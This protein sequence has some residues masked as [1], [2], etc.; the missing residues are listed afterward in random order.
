MT[1]L[2]V[3]FFINTGLLIT[4]TNTDMTWWGLPKDLSGQLKDTNRPWSQIVGVPIITIII[5]NVFTLFTGMLTDVVVKLVKERL[6]KFR[7]VLQLQ[8][9]ELYEGP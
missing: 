2:W 7:A 9:N 4:L 3:A 6:L 1:K 8:L 5:V